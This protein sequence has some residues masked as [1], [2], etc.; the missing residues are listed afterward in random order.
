MEGETASYI[1]LA[2]TV[3]GETASYT[4]LAE[5]VEGETVRLSG[6]DSRG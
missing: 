6:R 5:T 1:D 3:E 2:E 4:D